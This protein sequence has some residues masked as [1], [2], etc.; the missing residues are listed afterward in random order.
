MEQKLKELEDRIKKLEN[1]TGL[2]SGL[3]QSMIN[4]GF[5]KVEKA[6]QYTSQANLE[7]IEL[8]VR[9]NNNNKSNILLTARPAGYIGA[10]KGVDISNDRLISE[11][12]NLYDGAQ[13][14][15]I[16]TGALPSPLSTAVTYY[17]VSSD[18]GSFKV[19]LTSGGTA[20]NITDSG[21]GAHYWVFVT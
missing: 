19:S 4:R 11:S 1:P 8:V 10:I 2:P 6:I 18:G 21:L 3:E 20:I 15:L 9:T 12:N 14:N 13:V 16:S 5:M 17:V 7:W